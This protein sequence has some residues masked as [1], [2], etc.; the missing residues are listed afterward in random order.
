MRDRNKILHLYKTLCYI[1]LRYV[2]L[3]YLTL[4]TSYLYS[5]FSEHRSSSVWASWKSRHW[6]DMDKN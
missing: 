1:T 6:T 3:R 5:R 4:C 2:T